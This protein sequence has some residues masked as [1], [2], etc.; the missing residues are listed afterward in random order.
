MPQQRQAKGVVRHD[1][2]DPLTSSTT[3]RISIVG[4]V[5][6]S[7]LSARLIHIDRRPMFNVVRRAPS[8]IAR[9]SSSFPAFSRYSRP[10]NVREGQRCLPR[11]VS[12]RTAKSPLSHSAW[13]QSPAPAAVED[14]AVEGEIEQ[15]VFSQAPPSDEQLNQN[16]RQVARH[17]PVT[18]FAELAERGMVCQAVVD[19]ITKRMGLETMT[20]VQSKTISI[21]L[22]GQDM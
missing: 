14:E 12:L 2:E 9:S 20:E 10:V 18:K 5:T 1:G 8:S 21:S 4:F 13:R 16:A 22:K 11:L 17:G 3:V 19:T 7:R 6:M 15:E